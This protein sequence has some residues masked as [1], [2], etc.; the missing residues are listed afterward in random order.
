[1]NVS[2]DYPSAM[3]RFI[4][5]VC[6]ICAL[7]TN[8]V[9]AV[10][11]MSNVSSSTLMSFIGVVCYAYNDIRIRTRHVSLTANDLQH[12]W[13]YTSEAEQVLCRYVMDLF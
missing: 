7:P 2:D 6:D 3:S 5:P 12:A 1:M 9:Q 8:N 13:Y 11:V 10:G 4:Q